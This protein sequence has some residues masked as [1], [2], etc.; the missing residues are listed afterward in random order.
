MR[1]SRRIVGD[2]GKLIELFAPRCQ[3]RGTLDVLRALLG[4]PGRWR[5]AH[6]LFGTIRDRTLAAERANDRVRTAQ[7]LFEEVCA[8]SLFNLS[9]APAPFDADAPYWIVPNAFALARAL[10][11]L[12]EKVSEIVGA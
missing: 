7:Y 9:G 6:D 3:D 11:V 4:E 2:I 5:E 10:G 1:S 12:P 8:Q